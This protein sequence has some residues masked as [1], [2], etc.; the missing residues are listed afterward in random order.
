[1]LADELKNLLNQCGVDEGVRGSIWVFSGTENGHP[2]AWCKYDVSATAMEE[3]TNRTNL[4]LDA[5]RK[6]KGFHVEHK[7]VEKWARAAT[8]FHIKL[9]YE[10]PG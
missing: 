6:Q 1:M 3:W 10:R 9:R 8:D 2:V 4:L 7:R 5:I